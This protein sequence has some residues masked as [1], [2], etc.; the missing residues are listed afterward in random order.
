MSKLH[1]G[2]VIPGPI[3]YSETFFQSK[4]KGLIQAGHKVSVFCKYKPS[5]D[6]SFNYRFQWVLSSIT[7]IR[8]IQVLLG[9][10][11][12]LVLAPKRTLKFIKISKHDG[13]SL[14]QTIQQ[15][16][17]NGHI[18]CGPQLTHLHFGFTT[19]GIGREQLGKVLSCK[20]STSFRGY[21]I[22]IY[23]LMNKKGI[24]NKVWQRLDK[25]HT[26]SD[27]LLKLAYHHGLPTN[28]PVQKITPAI[29]VEN[30]TNPNKREFFSQ[31]IVRILT[32][33]RLTW[34]KG[35]AYALQ[36]MK[37]LKENNVKFKYTI[38]GGGDELE[39]IK[40]ECFNLG[41]DEDV[42]I[43]GKLG[44]KE[45]PELMWNNDIYLHPSIQEGFC[46]AVLEAQAA[47]MLCIVSNAEGL[48][49][50]VS[51]KETGWVLQARDANAISNKIIE[52]NNEAIDNLLVISNNAVER[53]KTQFNIEKQ[54]AEFV[55]FYEN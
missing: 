6:P 2:I 5:A 53:V 38:V 8:I 22:S 14:I 11:R 15:L 33:G 30:F 12:C 40:Y 44:H 18:I 7:P 19:M 16:Y 51:H 54:I 24:Y 13:L 41:I 52:L 35:Y 48:P 39:F 10:V 34:K 26:I 20:L 32:V 46:N 1:I 29:K 36:A 23:P 17:I 42:E 55:Q 4:I 37:K 47:G 21:D 45:I 31:D 49:E 50:N 27:A 43:I 25:V 9:L 28:I 3:S